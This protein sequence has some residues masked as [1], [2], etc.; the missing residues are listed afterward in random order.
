M[1]FAITL[2]LNAFQLG[3]INTCRLFLQ[4]T[5]QSDIVSAN[6]EYIVHCIMEGHSDECRGTDLLWPNIPYPSASFW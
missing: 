3:C 1:D 5:T 2:S 6:G 4:V